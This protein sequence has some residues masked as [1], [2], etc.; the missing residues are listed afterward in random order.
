[1]TRLLAV[2]VRGAAAWVLWQVSRDALQAR[3][4]QL[5]L[6]PNVHADVVRELRS[7]AL[8]LEEA[9]R[10]YRELVDRSRSEVADSVE[11]LRGGPDAGLE[12]PLHRWVEVSEV[13][14]LLDCSPRW[15]TALCQ[16]GRLAATKHG[17]EW[18]ID[19]G[20]VKDFKRRE[21]A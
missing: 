2:P 15:V 6:D 20:S 1:M 16:Q 13:A 12:N 18:R 19:A 17:R 3:I 21:A 5:S 4:R 7:V 14:A 9:A 10:Q 8:D 11:R